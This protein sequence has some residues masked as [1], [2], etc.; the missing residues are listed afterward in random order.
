MNR[1][2]DWKFFG[3]IFGF[4]LIWAIILIV[5]LPRH[6]KQTTEKPA[7]TVT[8]S[9]SN[10]P[11]PK[12]TNS[13]PMDIQAQLYKIGE[14]NHVG[15]QIRTN[16]HLIDITMGVGGPLNH[17]KDAIHNVLG[18]DFTNYQIGVDVY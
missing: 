10:T 14:E 16:L 13:P 7:V 12:S 18:N 11:P 8:N 9:V 15:I 2:E 1:N 3:G 4:I 6:H 5:S 17:V